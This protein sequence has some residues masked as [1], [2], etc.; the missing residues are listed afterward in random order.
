MKP[1]TKIAYFF[2]L[3]ALGLKLLASQQIYSSLELFVGVFIVLGTAFMIY[4]VLEVSN[5]KGNLL[6]ENATIS[7]HTWVKPNQKEFLLKGGTSYLW[8]PRSLFLNWKDVSFIKHFLYGVIASLGGKRKSKGNYIIFKPNK[9]IFV[10]EHQIE[11]LMDVSSVKLLEKGPVSNY[12]SNVS[13]VGMV[14][15]YQIAFLLV[16]YLI[17]YIILQLL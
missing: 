6:F 3:I 16:L 5:L 7:K 14:I 1:S 4:A 2:F 9:D 13:I 8:I 10:K 15:S 11:T 12:D 17:I